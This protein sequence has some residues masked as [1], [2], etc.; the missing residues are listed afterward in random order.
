MEDSGATIQKKVTKKIKKIE[1]DEEEEEEEKESVTVKNGTKPSNEG[2]TLS[3]P[4]KKT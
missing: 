3:R 2:M 4:T 1:S